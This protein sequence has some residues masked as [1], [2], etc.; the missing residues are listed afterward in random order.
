MKR[1]I[2]DRMSTIESDVTMPVQF[3]SPKPLQARIKEFFTTNQLVTV[4]AAGK[5][6]V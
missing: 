4:H 1:N 6:S 2:Q 3:I 5:Y